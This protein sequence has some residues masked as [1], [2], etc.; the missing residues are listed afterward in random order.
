MEEFR[1]FL[2]ANQWTGTH[3]HKQMKKF[4]LLAR[5]TGATYS[6]TYQ[7]LARAWNME[8]SR[9]WV[10]D[11]NVRWVIKH[12]GQEDQRTDAWHNARST[13]ITASEVGD[14]IDGTPASR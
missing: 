10:R 7:Q 14:V 5:R 3:V 12:Y 9:Y 1:L 13:M 8:E 4:A 2:H 11:R 6:K